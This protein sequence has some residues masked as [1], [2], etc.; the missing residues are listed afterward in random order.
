MKSYPQAVLDMLDSGIVNYCYG[1]KMEFQS[2]ILFTDAGFVVTDGGDSY[3]PASEF[4][5]I[6]DFEKVA[7]MEISEV[8]LNFSM[9]SGTMPA[10]TY[11]DNFYQKKVSLKRFFLD[12]NNQVIH[13]EVVWKG[14]TKQSGD[15]ESTLSI[16]VTN[17]WGA[18]NN[19]NVWRTTPASHK[20]RYPDDECFKYAH[21]AGETLLWGG[22]YTGAKRMTGGAV[23]YTARKAG[24]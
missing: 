23:K 6:E 1:L 15:D 9:L 19:S 10:I 22:E 12:D 14:L 16:A 21:K 5:G 2:P 8:V 4:E 3:T 13:S 24:R 18:F 17:H 20:R 11:S 7:D